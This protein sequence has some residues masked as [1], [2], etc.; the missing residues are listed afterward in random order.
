MYKR[1]SK[2]QLTQQYSPSSCVEDIT[3]Y[4]NAYIQQSKTA[5]EKAV[6]DKLVLADLKYTP[7]KDTTLDL[8]LPHDQHQTG[9]SY[10]GVNNNKKLH[11]YIHGGY[12]QELSKEESCFAATNFQAH[13][14]YFAVVNYSLAP[15][16]SLSEIVEQ[17][18]HAI[19]WLYQHA[20][21][22][23]YDKNEIYLSGS[24]AG[25]HLAIMMLKTDWSKYISAKQLEEKLTPIKGICAVS[26]IYDLTPIAQTYINEPLQLTKADILNNSPLLSTMPN[27]GATPCKIIISYGDNETSEFKRQSQE[28]KEKLITLG[29]QV[30]FQE[31]V[32]RNHFDVILDLANENSWLFTQVL[33]QMNIPIQPL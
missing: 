8:Y 27:A 1:F 33:Q 16:A 6:K 12:W 31:I 11:V 22:Y 19:A 7:H 25:A 5:K 23:G 13:N 26:G 20:E 24:S 17:N 4:I 14:C 32:A 10:D 30:S 28:F 3:I 29:Y 18:R 9:T 15:S 2:S 21:H